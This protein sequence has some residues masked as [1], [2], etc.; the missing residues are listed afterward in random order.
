VV[1]L[2]AGGSIRG[3]AR[4]GIAFL[5][6]C[7][8]EAARKRDEGV[9]FGRF[10]VVAAA[11][12][13]AGFRSRSIILLVIAARSAAAAVLT[14]TRRWSATGWVVAPT[15]FILDFDVIVV[16][17]GTAVILGT[18]VVIAPTTG[19]TWGDFISITIRGVSRA[20]LFGSILRRRRRR[21]EIVEQRVIFQIDLATVVLVGCGFVERAVLVVAHK[22][23]VVFIVT[24]A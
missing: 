7:I 1:A 9:L 24:A 10:L 19:S 17:T 14:G 11:S 18:T 16:V 4:G 3:V 20:T 8:V 23:M 6:L 22:F 5:V 2:W 13:T 21:A 15:V 12:G